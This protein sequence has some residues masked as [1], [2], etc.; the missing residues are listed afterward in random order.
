[1]ASGLPPPP[2]RSDQGSF[3]WTA[4]YNELYTLLSTTGSVAWTLVD[5]AGSSIADLQDKAHSRLTSIQ[6]NGEF[7]LN[8]TEQSRVAGF[9]TKTSN[10]TT[11]DIA[12]GQWAL[13]KNTTSGE[14]RLWANDG[15]TMKSVLLT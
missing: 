3:A 9:L 14:V 13:Y 15:G 7:H 8:A 2:T 4:W 11:S 10:P 6:G 1:M 5:K 12:A